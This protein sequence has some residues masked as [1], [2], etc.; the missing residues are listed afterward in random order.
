MLELWGMGSTPLLS[1]HPDPL[2]SAM[3]AP[4]N[5]P[6]CG[7]NKTNCILMLN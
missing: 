5:G 4:D 7:L 6:T 2:W 3:V 1:L